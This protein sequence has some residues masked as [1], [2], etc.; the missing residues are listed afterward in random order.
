MY[1]CVCVFVCTCVQFVCVCVASNCDSI[2]SFCAVL[3]F[4][5]RIKTRNFVLS[6]SWLTNLCRPAGWGRREPGA[7]WRSTWKS[8][9]RP[10]GP[11]PVGVLLEDNERGGATSGW[12]CS[13]GSRHASRGGWQW[14]AHSQTGQRLFSCS[15]P[16][17]RN[18]FLWRKLAFRHIDEK[19]SIKIRAFSSF[20]F[21]EWNSG[22][23]VV[24]IFRFYGVHWIPSTCYFIFSC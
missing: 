20:L 17:S 12:A 15:D 10:C 22:T 11:G 18:Y 24:G 19:V 6:R 5:K 21:E 14:T 7:W 13:A 4:A 23:F 3:G 1:V 9:V 16:N 8:H 2:L